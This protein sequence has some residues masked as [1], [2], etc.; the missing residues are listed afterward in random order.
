VTCAPENVPTPLVDQLKEGGRMVIP[1]GREEQRLYLM[2]KR[3]GAMQQREMIPVRF[4]PM[5]RG[6]P[7]PK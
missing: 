4:V 5:T 6:A 2:E 7:R 1:V 3:G